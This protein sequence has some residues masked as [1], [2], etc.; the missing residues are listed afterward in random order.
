M[1]RGQFKGWV[2]KMWQD[3]LYEHITYDEPTSTLSKYWHEYKW[4]L[5]KQYRSYQ[6][7]EREKDEFKRKH[8]RW[9]N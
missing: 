7:R 2:H 6:Q 1:N 4:W 5:R 9:V 8:G 3:N